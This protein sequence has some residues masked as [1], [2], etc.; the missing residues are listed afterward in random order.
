M[1]GLTLSGARTA[2][3][4]IVLALAACAVLCAARPAMARPITD[5]I[6]RD[7]LVA[8]FARPYDELIATTQPNTTKATTR[9]AEPSSLSMILGFL[10]ASGL[11]P[12]EGQVFA[13]SAMVLPLL[14]RFEHVVALLDVSTRV[15]REPND[16]TASE[17]S[18]RLEQ[19]QV[20]LIL[21]TGGENGP[22]LDQLNRIVGRYTHRDVAALRADA[23]AGFPYYR[24]VDDRLYGWAVWEWGPLGDDFVVSFGE[25]S[26]NRIAET[27]ARKL[28]SLGADPWYQAASKKTLGDE[29]DA[30]LFIALSRLVAQLGPAAQG[31]VGRTI[32]ALNADNIT[33]D[34]WTIGRRGRAMSWLRCYRRDGEDV[35]HRFSD[36]GDEPHHHRRI[37]PAAARRYAIIRTPTHW[38][39]DNLPRAWVAAQTQSD[40]DTWRRIWRRLEEETGIDING[41][42]IA[43]L[44]EHVVIHDY[45]P[46]P[47]EIPFALTVAFEIDDKKSVKLATDA[48][49]SAWSRYLDQRAERKGTTLMRV[50][51]RHAEDG[52]W[53]LQAGLL[54][55]AMK[56]TDRY[57]V[58]SWSPQALRQA[59]AFI[60]VERPQ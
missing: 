10:N 43:H 47:L 7:V 21:R 30:K 17:V 26:F 9:P 52:V 45:P 40:I 6:P 8:Y 14:G 35:V 57:V 27:Y 11:I 46:H 24:L 42:L 56:V 13:D 23:V 48:L 3:G 1:K 37:V 29:A 44:G 33:H 34:L 22:V 54:G 39:I 4:L 19:L 18:L 41:N 5:L 53:Y 16:A 2:G 50:K 60:E 49:L 32:E 28:P 58:L 15:L 38:L 31:R 25:G 55:P 36:P 20:V 51:V 59:L 12:D